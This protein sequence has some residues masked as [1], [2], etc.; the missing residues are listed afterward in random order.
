VEFSAKPSNF[1]SQRFSEEETE[2]EEYI[3]NF[4]CFYKNSNEI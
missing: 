4:V 2:V 3:Q 1:Y